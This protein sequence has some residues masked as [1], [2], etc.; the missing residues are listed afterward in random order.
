MALAINFILIP[1][2]KKL[3]EDIKQ[4]KEGAIEK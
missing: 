4:I 3:P 2:F 1:I